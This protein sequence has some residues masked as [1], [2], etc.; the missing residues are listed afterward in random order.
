M[1]EFKGIILAGGA[2]SRLHPITLGSSKQLLPIY[3]KPMIYYPISVLLLSGIRDILVISTPK[4]LPHYQ[5]LL[6]SGS[7]FG[8]NFSYAEQPEPKGL[9]EAF[10]I[11]SDFIGSKNVCL[12]LGDNIF[13]GQHFSNSLYDAMSVEKGATIFGYHVPNPSQFGVVEFDQ[14]GLVLTIE[15]K[16]KKPKSSIAATGLY[17]YDN[18]VIEIVKDIKPSPRGELEITDVNNFYLSQKQLNVQMLGRGFAWLDTGTPD[19]LIE[20]GKFVQTVEHTQGLKIA[21]LEEIAFNNGW[22]NAEE[23]DERAELFI[24]TSYGQYLRKI[25]RGLI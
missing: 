25:A 3:D 17:F 4:D 21:C 15:E 8:V 11:G 9:A 2:G 12:I 7:Q 24:Q 5:N 14:N 19:S 10:L 16:P 22:I 18:K 13:F 1:N 20:A 6:G 23:L